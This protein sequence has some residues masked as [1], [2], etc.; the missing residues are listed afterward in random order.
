MKADQY[1]SFLIHGLGNFIE[2]INR[3]HHLIIACFF[4]VSIESFAGIFN[5]SVVKHMSNFL[6]WIF[7]TGSFRRFI[8]GYSFLKLCIAAVIRLTL[9]QLN[10]SIIVVHC[11]EQICLL[12]H[13][14]LFFCFLVFLLFIFFLFIFFLL[15]LVLIFLLLGFFALTLRILLYLS[16]L[17]FSLFSPLFRKRIVIRKW[18]QCTS[19]QKTGDTE[20]NQNHPH[21][22]LH[23][24]CPFLFFCFSPMNIYLYKISTSFVHL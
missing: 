10:R 5:Q 22:F 4:R 16:D 14:F 18:K 17:F 2:L 6:Q 1:I 12:L 9:K 19:A 23:V 21:I 24:S 15:F 11:R 7:H 3:C 20:Q 13:R 8:P